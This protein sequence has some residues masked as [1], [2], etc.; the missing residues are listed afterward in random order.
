MKKRTCSV[1]VSRCAFNMRTNSYWSYGEREI[2][3]TF[4]SDDPISEAMEYGKA[5]VAR[6]KLVIVRPNFNDERTDGKMGFHE[7]RSFDGEDLR[8][9]EFVV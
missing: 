4:E 2:D 6:G 1:I 9:V 3:K 8:K 5:L 7:F